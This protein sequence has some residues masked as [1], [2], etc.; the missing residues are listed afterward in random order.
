M[1]I[2]PLMAKTEIARRYEDVSDGMQIARLLERFLRM[3]NT[4]SKER[5]M[6]KLTLG[7]TVTFLSQVPLFRNLN[8][9][10]LQGLAKSMVRRR[11]AAGEVLVRQGNG[12][13][14]LFIV[15]S[16]KAEAVHT[17]VNGTQVVVNTFGPTDFFGELAM[18]RNE[19]R[20]ASVVALEDT[21]CLV[22]VQWEFMGKLARNAKM[23]TVILQE[24]SR[25]FQRALSVL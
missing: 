10:Q 17:R 7:K 11:Y 4:V 20:T 13:I 21:E 12:G 18:L 3:R 16:G 25:R 15:V 23:A 2:D 22:L 9:G 6:P 14:A 19:P 1:M 5:D 24:Q 8:K